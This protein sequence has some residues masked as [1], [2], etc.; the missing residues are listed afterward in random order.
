MINLNNMEEVFNEFEDVRL[1]FAEYHDK[2]DIY[3]D[4]Y[5]YS[6]IKAPKGGSPRQNSEL[7]VNMLKTFA[8]K[9]MFYTSQ[10]PEFKV[11]PAGSG[12]LVREFADIRE[13][14]LYATHRDSMTALNQKKWAFDGTIRSA[15]IAETMIDWKNRC[16]LVNRY[17]PR[18]AYWQYANDN[19]NTLLAFWVAYPM[20]KDQV[21][22]QWGKDVGDG[23]IDINEVSQKTLTRLDGRDWVVVLKRWDGENRLVIA[24]DTWIEKPHKHQLGTIPIDI[25]FPF[26]NGSDKMLGDFY[27]RQLVPLQAEFNDAWRK[28]S[29]IVRKLGN[30]LVWSRGM[31]ARQLDEAKKAMRG[32]GGFIGLKG[33]GELGILQIPETN[34]IDNHLIDL[35]NRM[36]D[37]AG[38]P[39]ATFGEVVGSNTSGD[40]LG[41]Y[42]TPTMRAID[43]QNIAWRAFYE[44]INW[45]ILKG[46]DV[47]LK[48]GETKRL[49]GYLP[50]GTFKGINPVTG[51]KE[52]TN[53]AY[54]EDLTKE[55]IDKNYNSVV[56]FKAVTPKDDVAY[57][58]LLMDMVNSKVL[59]RTT[60]YE[61][62]GLM[63]PQDELELLEEEQSNPALNPEG[64][65]QLLN[66]APDPNQGLG[67]AP[68]GLPP[69][70]A[71]I[72]GLPPVGGPDDIAPAITG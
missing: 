1:D 13:K 67:G 25:A 70:D 69:L 12:D 48:T 2:M 54:D 72:E 21:K 55:A 58:R 46:Y 71:G 28:R 8:D 37:L 68:A 11:P 17:D 20:T 47:M 23:P 44:A 18:F 64:L 60:A 39:T 59:S 31:V 10:M 35:F 56:E 6:A 7:V 40:A 65:S 43:D 29:N 51:K 34:M 22:R 14:A 4:Y 50:R 45:K 41:M 26:Q 53:A 49:V 5:D 27:L 33:Q 62:M 38:F 66:A 36:K 16:V 61:E 30:P 42:F 19:D 63:S 57:K 3:K 15:A 9:N 52:Y 32:D 24:G